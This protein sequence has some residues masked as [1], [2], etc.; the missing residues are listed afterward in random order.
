MEA[1]EVGECCESG[2]ER[3]GSLVRVVEGLPDLGFPRW[4]GRERDLGAFLL[5]LGAME[6]EG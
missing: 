6:K 1:G 4:R 2:K 3:G 5:A